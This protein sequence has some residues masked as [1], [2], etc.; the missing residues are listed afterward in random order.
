[1]SPYAIGVTI[2]FLTVAL[3]V[4]VAFGEDKIGA[5]IAWKRRSP[6]LRRLHAATAAVQDLVAF[7]EQRRIEDRQQWRTDWEKLEQPQPQPEPQPQPAVAVRDSR[8][9]PFGN[10]LFHATPAGATVIRDGQGRTVRVI[11]ADEAP[12]PPRGGSGVSRPELRAGGVI[13]VGNKIAHPVRMGKWVGHYVIHEHNGDALLDTDQW[14][15]L[16]MYGD[17]HYSTC[18]YECD[19]PDWARRIS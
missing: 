14:T 12:R 8:E 7:K 19:C 11:P 1:M 6:D 9:Q 3:A 4:A 15:V 18:P 13:T 16:K 10:G 2:G 17:G 5:I